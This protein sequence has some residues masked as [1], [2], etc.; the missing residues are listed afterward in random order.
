MITTEH[1]YVK[2]EERGTSVVPQIHGSLRMSTCVSNQGYRIIKVQ[3]SVSPERMDGPAHQ[4]TSFCTPAFQNSRHICGSAKLQMTLG[5]L[6][7][8]G[9]MLSNLQRSRVNYT[10]KNNWMLQI[11]KPSQKNLQDV[12]F[13]PTWNWR[14][15]WIKYRSTQEK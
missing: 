15:L 2:L 11:A 8:P 3:Q 1:W 5:H 6:G 14:V 7:K 9:T 13:F 4:V 12:Y 10:M